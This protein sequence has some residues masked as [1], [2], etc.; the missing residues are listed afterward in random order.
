MRYPGA[1]VTSRI[2]RQAILRMSG[3][4]AIMIYERVLNRRGLDMLLVIEDLPPLIT[5]L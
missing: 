5:E 2:F 3:L 1:I 4:E